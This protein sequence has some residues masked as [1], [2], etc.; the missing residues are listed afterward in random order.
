MKKQ[1]VIKQNVIKGQAGYNV[2][3]EGVAFADV[4]TGALVAMLV[5]SLINSQIDSQRLENDRI[6]IQKLAAQAVE[7][8][9][10]KAKSELLHKEKG[11]VSDVKSC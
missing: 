7:Q 2:K 1:I 4:V 6:V 9:I 11:V 3:I 8:A 10:D 5:T